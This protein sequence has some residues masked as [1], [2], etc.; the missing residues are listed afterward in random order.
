[1]IKGEKYRVSCRNLFHELKILTGISLYI[2]E[3]YFMKKK[4]I[5]FTLPSTL[6]SMVI[7]PFINEIYTYNSV[8]PSVVRGVINMG[9]EILNGFPI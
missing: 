5:R 2:F 1:V 8:T 9:T 7:I 6:M 4:K 3:I